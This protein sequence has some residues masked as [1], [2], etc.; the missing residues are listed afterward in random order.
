MVSGGHQTRT[1]GTVAGGKRR[2]CFE[3]RAIP[4]R[5]LVQPRNRRFIAHASISGKTACSQDAL[6]HPGRR[7]NTL[8]QSC[9]IL[10]PVI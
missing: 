10:R 9:T 7:D 3:T 1:T 6:P 2:R 8:A 5:G 4:P